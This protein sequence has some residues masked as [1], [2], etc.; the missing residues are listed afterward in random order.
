MKILGLN[1][2]TMD[3]HADIHVTYTS[4]DVETLE[5]INPDKDYMLMPTKEV[6]ALVEAID[7]CTYDCDNCEFAE[8][9]EDY[10]DDDYYEDDGYLEPLFG[11]AYYDSEGNF[12]Y[13]NKVIYNS[14]KTIV[15]WNDGTKTSS[16]CGEKDTYSPEMGLALAVLKKITSGEFTV[17]TLHDW[18]P[19]D[20]T[21]TKTIKTLKDVRREH[22]E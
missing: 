18:A 9:C 1:L 3:K 16:T 10:A 7:D 14:P 15:F 13:I 4:G 5:D 19:E 11:G 6:Q 12:I 2:D 8:Y 17:R 20:N 22:K 21:I